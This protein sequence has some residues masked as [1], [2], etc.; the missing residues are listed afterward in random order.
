M[1]KL[2]ASIRQKIET[3]SLDI[4][5]PVFLLNLILEMKHFFPNLGEINVWDEANYIQ[6]G[7]RLLTRGYLPS[8]AGSPLSSVMFGLSLWPVA[9]SPN[10]FVLGDAIARIFLF[11]MLFFS[12]YLV[13]RALR[14][15]ANAWVKIGR[16]HV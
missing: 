13:A 12:T 6:N 5:I 8:L 1:R 14:P 3:L 11:I 10:F 2:T 15:Y 9:G 7:V 16:A 4:V